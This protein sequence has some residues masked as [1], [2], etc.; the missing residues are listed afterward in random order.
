MRKTEIAIKG[1]KVVDVGYR[2][3]LLLN[4][5]NLGIDKVFAYNVEETVR[6]RV[7]GAEG[8][9]DQFLDLIRSTS[10]Q[11]AEVD[12]IEVRD[13][14]GEVMQASAFLQFLQFEQINKAIPAILSIDRKQDTMIGKQDTMIG[15]QDTMIGK[16]DTMIG[17]Q[18]TM[19]E[20]QDAMLRKQDQTLAVLEG[21]RE[22]TSL[23][24]KD[25]SSIKDDVS[26]LARQTTLEDLK[27]KYEILSRDVAEIKAEIAEIRAV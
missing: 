21:V 25:V 23:I 13:F 5:M 1:P 22:D 9:I 8:K 14:E 16:Q 4:A 6:V 20:K 17:K 3:F 18:D 24:R 12:E 2:P 27:K 26:T 11:H 15:K 19:I 10:P 7:Q